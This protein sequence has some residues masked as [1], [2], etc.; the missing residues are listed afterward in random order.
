[1]YFDEIPE[2]ADYVFTD[3]QWMFNNLTEIVYQSYL[4]HDHD[5]IKVETDFK[6][7]GFF[8]ESLLDKCEL[9][10]KHKSESLKETEV[11]F[12]QGFIKLLEYLRIVAPL[13]EEDKEIVYFMPSLL[14]TCDLTNYQCAV[15]SE[16]LPQDATICDKTEPLLIQF[17]LNDDRINSPGSFPRGTFCCLII[18]LLQDTSMWRLFWLDTKQKVFDN[19]VTLLYRQTGQYFT[20]ID[21]IFY[22]EVV[23]LQ[24]KGCSFNLNHYEIKQI[25]KEA[26]HKIGQKLNFY[27]FK[28]TFSFICQKCLTEGKHVL[29]N[30]VS[31]LM[32]DCIHGHSAQSSKYSI[33]DKVC[34][35]RLQYSVYIVSYISLRMNT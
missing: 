11:D 25:L 26:L 34:M 19:L 33:W 32:Y 21:R 7:K 1:M 17:R 8:T 2:L 12:K 24:D 13:K 23:L 5:N 22:L 6:W 20:F 10:L 27:N 35:L 30:K 18:E 28:L 16:V 3:Y 29:L 31:H 9:K 15:P 14:S 4:K